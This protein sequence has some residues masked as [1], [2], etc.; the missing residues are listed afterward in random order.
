MKGLSLRNYPKV[1]SELRGA[2][3]TAR[4]LS[5]LPEDLHSALESG[6]VIA[7]SW[8]P[9]EWKRAMHRAAREV[10]GEA[11]LAWIMGAEMTRRDLSGIYRAFMRVVSPRYVLSFGSQI[12]STYFRP[13]RMRVLENR[14]GFVRVR[15]EGCEGFN[16]DMWQDVLGGCEATLQ[17]AGGKSVRLIIEEGLGR[18]DAEGQVVASWTRADHVEDYHT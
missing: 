9:V 17:A 4:M 1:L 6:K 12:F 15:F 13:G 2:E 11:G 10:T 8:Y 18:N 14:D 7:S 3:V 5:A 16:L